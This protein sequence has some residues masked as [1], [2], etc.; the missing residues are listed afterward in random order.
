MSVQSTLERATDE[1]LV[2]ARQLGFP[3]HG[4]GATVA[5]PQGYLLAEHLRAAQEILSTPIA[6]SDLVVENKRVS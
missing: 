2:I 1:A 5:L 6:I 3:V 4:E